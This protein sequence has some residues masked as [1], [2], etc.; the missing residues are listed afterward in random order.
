MR[1]KHYLLMQDAE[2]GHTGLHQEFPVAIEEA[3][4]SRPPV[5]FLEHHTRLIV[6][7]D[8]PASVDRVPGDER[9]P[10]ALRRRVSTHLQAPGGVLQ[11]HCLAALLDE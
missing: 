2:D 11:E 7:R 10:S 1:H 9:K 3:A 4:N 8:D 5:G 6:A